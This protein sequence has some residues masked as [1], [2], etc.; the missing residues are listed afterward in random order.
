V[1]NEL[2]RAWK[3]SVVADKKCPTVCLTPAWYRTGQQTVCRGSVGRSW[4]LYSITG[5]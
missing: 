5:P 4:L 2:E 3:E 1:N